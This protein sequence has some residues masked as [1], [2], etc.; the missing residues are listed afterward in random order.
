MKQVRIVIN[1]VAV[2]KAVEENMSLLDFLRD[3]LH[4]KG[5][6]CGCRKGECGAC[7][8]IVDGK[9]VDSCLYPVLKADGARVTTVE[10]LA[11]EGQLSSLQQAFIQ[12]GA[13]QC[14]FC[15][16]GMLMSAEALLR[17]TPHPTQEQIRRAVDGNICRCTGYTKIVEAISLA[18]GQ[19]GGEG[20]HV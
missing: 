5:T 18:A 7:T 17:E 14:G 16:P 9:A 3:E 13:V 11:K 10:G 8:V 20:D 1:D 4:L 6:K 15:T 12:T 2:E 19:N